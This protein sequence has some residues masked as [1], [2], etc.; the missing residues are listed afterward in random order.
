MADRVATKEDGLGAKISF[1]E[2]LFLSH[3]FSMLDRPRRFRLIA[4][5]LFKKL[6]MHMFGSLDGE[7]SARFSIS[8]KIF[9]NKG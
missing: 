3:Q 7:Q 6:T 9:S 5:R 1:S 2:N 4:T 8:P